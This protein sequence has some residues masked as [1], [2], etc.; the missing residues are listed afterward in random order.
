[1]GPRCAVSLFLVVATLG[2]PGCVTAREQQVDWRPETPYA[3][4]S[5]VYS[6]SPYG[7]KRAMFAEAA[8]SGAAG[9]RLDLQVN[10]VF[11]EPQPRWS[12]IDEIVALS[13]EFRIRVTG[14][15]TGTPVW[16][17][18]CDWGTPWER[19]GYCPPKDAQ[20]YARLVSA[21]VRRTKPYIDT[22]EV[23][24]EPDGAWNYTGIAQDYAATLSH[25]YDAIK[26]ANPRARVLMGGVMGP[27]SMPWVDQVFATPGMGAADKFDVANV[28]VRGTV[29][30]A[31]GQVKRWSRFFAERGIHRPLWVTEHGYPSDPAYQRD[32][33]FR[34]G[35]R[36]Q[37]GYLRASLRT[38]LRAGAARVFVT[39]RDNLDGEFA[40][41]GILGGTVFDPPL[42][43]PEVRRKPAFGAFRRLALRAARRA[44]ARG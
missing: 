32:P 35:E 21:I 13:R 14:I 33:R 28:H 42:E 5:R 43:A 9:I 22:F 12:Q 6:S 30:G 8:A 19:V 20:A 7:F 23:L 16:L 27:Y 11:E 17:A 24:N 15:L 3:L 18:R 2:L 29:A 36:S 37:A 38:L 1:M 44:A 41:E 39:Q 26:R 31:G 4:H 10:A 40:S 34:H 25:C